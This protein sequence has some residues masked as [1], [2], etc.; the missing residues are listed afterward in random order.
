MR[1]AG[2]FYFG[3]QPPSQPAPTP[4]KA[5]GTVPLPAPEPVRPAVPSLRTLRSR[6]SSPIGTRS[7]ATTPNPLR[8]YLS[9]YPDGR[10][11]DIARRTISGPRPSSLPPAS[12]AP[13]SAPVSLPPSR[14]HAIL[15]RALAAAGGARLLALRDYEMEAAISVTTPNGPVFD[16]RLR[17]AKCL[18]GQHLTPAANPSRASPALVSTASAPGIPNPL[19]SVGAPKKKNRTGVRWGTYKETADERAS[20]LRDPLFILREFQK[21]GWVLESSAFG[22]YSATRR[23][24]PL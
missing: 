22:P 23:A 14:A 6:S 21:P 16:A 5:S 9:R 19:E 15:Q 13:E 3:A 18:S 1:I 2:R 12:S 24:G 8:Q 7:T 4:V 10:F 11:A 17:R 20:V